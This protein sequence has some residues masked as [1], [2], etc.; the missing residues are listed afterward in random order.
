MTGDLISKRKQ[1]DTRLLRQYFQIQQET[2]LEL[3]SFSIVRSNTANLRKIKIKK[4]DPLKKKRRAERKR[5]LAVEFAAK[6]L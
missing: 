1:K 3:K 2:D 4:S 6:N 5:R